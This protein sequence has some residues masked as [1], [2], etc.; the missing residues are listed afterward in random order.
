[1]V[2]FTTRELKSIY[3]Q[4]TKSGFSKEQIRCLKGSIKEREERNRRNKIKRNRRNISRPTNAFGIN[5]NIRMPRLR[6]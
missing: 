3:K 2:G 1:M 6:F 4:G 5:T